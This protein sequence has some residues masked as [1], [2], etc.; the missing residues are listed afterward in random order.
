MSVHHQLTAGQLG[1]PVLTHLDFVTV[2]H[3]NI[4]FSALVKITFSDT[5]SPTTHGVDGQ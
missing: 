1:M 5:F 2:G 4:F 3:D